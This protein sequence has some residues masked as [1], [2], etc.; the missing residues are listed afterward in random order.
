MVY[1]IEGPQERKHYL[2]REALEFA[3]SVKWDGVERL[4]RLF[5]DYIG[6]PD[7][8]E[9]EEKTRAFFA[10]VLRTAN[11]PENNTAP[12]VALIAEEDTDD[13]DGEKEQSKSH[14]LGNLIDSRTMVASLSAYYTYDP[15]G[16]GIEEDTDARESV[17]GVII[18]DE[19]APEDIDPAD[20]IQ[21]DL[22]TVTKWTYQHRS[23]KLEHTSEQIWAEAFEIYSAEPNGRREALA[24]AKRLATE[25]QTRMTRDQRIE[26]SEEFSRIF[27]QYGFT[28]V[29]V[30]GKKLTDV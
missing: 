25:D 17:A 11:D 2:T 21:C 20:V 6:A 13:E 3:Q 4:G 19:R 5:V 8:P 7:T 30:L 22:S 14:T 1:T 12:R 29:D 9:T 18:T 27:K 28:W 26:H 15:D 16:Y 24:R 23:E 10:D